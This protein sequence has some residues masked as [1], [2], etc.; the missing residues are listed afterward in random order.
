MTGRVSLMPRHV[1]AA[2]PEDE[3]IAVHVL[4][5]H[6]QDRQDQSRHDAVELLPDGGLGVFLTVGHVQKILRRIGSKR[7]GQHFAAQILRKT[8][9]K[10][11]LIRDTG[12]TKKPR[13][14]RDELPHL[15]NDAEPEGGRHA[16]RSVLRSLW[17]RVFEVP[18]LSRL[19]VP[20]S[21]AYP[22]NPGYPLPGLRGTA[23]LSALLRCQGLLPKKRRAFSPSPGS[24]Q[25]AFAAT[26]PP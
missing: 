22:M 16:Q 15:A 2:L 9:P 25:A 24:V 7:T 23:C 4:E 20:K 26:G 1:W 18:A 12:L 6:L 21:G 10:L 8:L 17:W 3:R 5:A 13:V 11:G 14:P 19:R